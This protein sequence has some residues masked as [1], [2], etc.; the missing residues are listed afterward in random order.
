MGKNFQKSCQAFQGHSL[1]ALE[2]AD[3]EKDT[4]LGCLE[5]AGWKFLIKTIREYKP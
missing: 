2:E 1:P 5:H 3:F 4:W